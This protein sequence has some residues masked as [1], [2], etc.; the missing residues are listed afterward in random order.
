MYLNNV[1]A[2]VSV[3]KMGFSHI[4]AVILDDVLMSYDNPLQYQYA[5]INVVH[6][7]P[8]KKVSGFS[9]PA[10]S[11]Q[12]PPGPH[13]FSPFFPVHRAILWRLLS[14]HVGQS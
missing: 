2:I 3:D 13:F 6:L 7:R 10:W 5:I 11:P 1:K 14:S 9:S 12:T 4:D 8:K